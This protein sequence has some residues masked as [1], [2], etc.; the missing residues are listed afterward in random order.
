[1]LL[2]QNLNMEKETIPFGYAK[3]YMFK[4]ALSKASPHQIVYHHGIGAYSDL[5]SGKIFLPFVEPLDLGD[6]HTLLEHEE[7]HFKITKDEA[8]IPLAMDIAKARKVLNVLE[9]I[10][11]NEKMSKGRLEKVFKKLGGES[12]QITLWEHYSEGEK[13]KLVNKLKGK[14]FKDMDTKEIIKTIKDAVEVRKSFDSVG[15]FVRTHYRVFKRLYDVFI[16][17][18][19]DDIPGP[20]PG[21]YLENHHLSNRELVKKIKKMLIN[22]KVNSEEFARKEQYY[23][24]RINRKYFEDVMCIKPF[25]Q[26]DSRH[27]FLRPKVLILLDCSGSMMGQPEIRA[28]S[29]IEACLDT[30]DCTVI[31]HNQCYHVVTND[32]KEVN[33][34][35][36]TGD[37]WFDKLKPKD[38]SCDVFVVVTDLHIDDDEAKG[39]FEFGKFMKAKYKYLLGCSFEHYYKHKFLN[40]VFKKYYVGNYEQYI[41]FAKKLANKLV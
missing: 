35:P 34:L 17:D 29:F 40:A 39:L 30:L 14:L 8:V 15:K 19:P 23:G 25:I 11:V 33:E 18:L 9:D 10:L 20:G 4:Q 27:V 24:K 32:K 37:E 3:S 28:K 5:K 6:L 31:G 12:L 13:K 41:E 1:M 36:M 26:Q 38:Y 16:D 21:K 2:E 7:G 22:L